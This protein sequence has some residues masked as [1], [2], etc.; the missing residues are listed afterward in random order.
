VTRS[1]R[2]Q[3]VLTLSFAVMSLLAIAA[4]ADDSVR[5]TGQVVLMHGD[6]MQHEREVD[7]GVFLKTESGLLPL[8]ADAGDFAGQTVIARGR[9]DNGHLILTGVAAVGGTETGLGSTTATASVSGTKR[10]A[11][12]LFN[13]AD[14]TSQPFTAASVGQT[15][16]AGG[17]ADRSVANYYNEVSWGQLQLSGQT[18]GWYT[19]PATS[20]TCDP[21]TWATQA[22]QAAQAAGI[23]L[24]TFDYKT[25]VYPGVG[26]CGWGGL[27]QMPGN[28]NW[29][30]GSPTVGLMAHEL[31]H[32]FGLNHAVSVSCTLANGEKVAFG[33][34]CT[35]SEYGDPYDVMGAAASAYHVSGWHRAMLGL[36]S[37][38]QTV[39]NGGTYTLSP[40]EIQSGSPHGLRIPRG[41]GTYFDLEYRRPYGNFDAFSPTSAA[42]NGVTVRKVASYSTANKPMLIDTTPQTASFLDAPLATGQAFVDPITGIKVTTASV[43]STGAQVQ[44][45][46]VAAD[47][48]PPS[49]SITSPNGSV[50]LPATVTVSATDNVGVSKVE[51]YRNG[52]LVGTKTSAPYTFS[53][54][55]GQSGAYTLA[56]TA[57]DTSGIS[58]ASLN[59]TVN[60]T[61]SDTTPP[62]DATDFRPI[63]NTQTS[64][65]TSWTASTDGS[66]AF[67]RLYRGSTVV[68]AP[69]D[70]TSSTFTGLTCGTGYSLSI[71]AVDAAGNESRGVTISGWT[72]ACTGDTQAPTMPTG[73]QATA[74]SSTTV[75]LS[76]QPSTDNV[77]IAFY[78]VDRDGVTVAHASSTSFSNSGLTVGRIYRYNVTAYDAAGNASGTSNP[79]SV[80]PSA[81]SDTQPPTVPTSV[82]VTSTTSSTVALSWQPSTD[83]VGVAGYRIYRNAALVATTSSPGYIDSGLAAGTSYT[84]SVAAFDAAGNTSATSSTATGLTSPVADTQAPTAPG[85]L[86]AKGLKGRKIGLTWSAATDNVGVTAYQVFRDGVTVA[87]VAGPLGYTDNPGRGSHTY[88]VV[89]L[90]KVGNQSPP[91]NSVSVRI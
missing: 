17:A 66:V 9:R 71:A 5:I 7:E 64:I 54:V 12:I 89:A 43:S 63:Q 79:V 4:R 36:T 22:D 51:L 56:A 78:R 37:D 29:I 52:V 19:I 16:F 38:I 69:N 57:Q 80:Q 88:Y 73:L 82:Q 49:V 74:T 35:T 84:Y 53:W 13:F 42:V 10:V 41:D 32:N 87:I 24:S 83:N 40:V 44:I 62:T 90:D 3:L 70:S 26:L 68:A 33:A 77:G 58:S 85:N 81:T 59:V 6:D 65:A 34:N 14:D 31:G 45:E 18:F 25:Y 67:Y 48:T 75:Q 46:M 39:S 72:T 27:A 50:T 55:E 60:A 47:Y 76:W 61:Q 15:Y 21:G 11:V 30:N 86:Q 2:I 28:R 20:Q 23:D 91:S 8:P 1:L